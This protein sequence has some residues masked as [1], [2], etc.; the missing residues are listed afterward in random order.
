VS[1]QVE[2]TLE[3]PGF[4]EVKVNIP[5]GLLFECI[6]PRERVQNL[7]AARSYTFVVPAGS[8]LDVI[9]EAFCAN[10]SFAPPQGAP[11]RVTPFMPAA[12]LNSQREV[13]DYFDA[14]MSARA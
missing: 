2:L 6:A 11:M 12:S 7:M 3:N 8:K 1:F 14:R 13:W 5:K 9:V 10:R 4:E